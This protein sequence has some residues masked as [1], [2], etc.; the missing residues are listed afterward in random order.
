MPAT[1]P[2]H[3]AIRNKLKESV[4]EALALNDR[5]ESL[6][7]EKPWRPSGNFHGK[8]DFSQP[9][10]YA[11]I[12]NSVLDLHAAS[13]KLEQ[14]LRSELKLPQRRRGNSDA[15]TKLA[16]QAIVNLCEGA[17]DF[18]V[19]RVTREIDK[20]TRRASIAVGDIEVPRKLPRTP[21]QPERKCPFCEN[22][23]L[24]SKSL[25]GEIFCCNPACYD[26]KG[27]K[28]KARMEFSK[29]VG[30]WVMVWQDGIAGVPAA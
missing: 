6:V 4:G 29:L 5:L 22:R 30:D 13:R 24:R 18:S 11:P 1:V 12:A 26:D 8:V 20:W 14:D 25:E 15:N 7:A 2:A 9:P 21:G 19:R 23:T 27:R 3:I 10:W 17:D 16:L 28:P